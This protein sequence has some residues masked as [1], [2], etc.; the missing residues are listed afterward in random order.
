M[1]RDA[2]PQRLLCLVPT[3][4]QTTLESL[5]SSRVYPPHAVLFQ[6]DQTADRIFILRRGNVKLSM[7]S[8][9]GDRLPLW[10]AKPGEILGLSACVAGG[11]Y[12]GTA[13]TIGDADVAVVPRQGFLDAVRTEQLASLQ[14]LTLLCDQLQVAHE[15]VRWVTSPASTEIHSISCPTRT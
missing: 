13:E 3:E 7:Q 6:P 8:N 5:T 12:E 14:C 11:C 1:D 9:Q 15:R 2:H 10:I 4:L